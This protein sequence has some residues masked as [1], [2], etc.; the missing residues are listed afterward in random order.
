MG[1]YI[2]FEIIRQ[3]PERV[4]KLAL[5]DTSARPDTREQTQRRRVLMSLASE[6]RFAEV[7]EQ[8]FRVYIL[9]VTATKV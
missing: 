9:I 8:A 4:V 7:P 3:A 2:A 5:L 6:G 1:G